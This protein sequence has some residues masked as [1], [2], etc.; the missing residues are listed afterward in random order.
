VKSPHE[1]SL[2]E[3]GGRRLDRVFS[4]VREC[5]KAGVREYDVSMKF[6]ELLLREGS[7]V[8]IRTRMFNMETLPVCV[9]SGKSAANFSSMDSPSGGGDGIS[10]A[11]PQCAGYK[12]IEVGEP[13]IIDTA[14]IHEGYHIDCTRV[15]AAGGL[16]GSFTRAHTVSGLCHELFIKEA[17]AGVFI[18]ELCQRVRKLVE[19]EGLQD[20][21][22]GGVKFIGH[23]VGLELDEFPVLAEAFEVRLQAGMAI[24]FEPKFVFRTGTVGYENTYIIEEGKARTI[25]H[26]EHN[27]QK[28]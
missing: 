10:V 2:M 21:F 27:I 6:V 1:L 7:S 22:M 13:V 8:R 19:G 14:L 15:F 4:G 17:R 16:D 20:I 11:V 3:E 28:V 24:A 25:N 26:V 12:K 9:L 5:I 18:P 23:S